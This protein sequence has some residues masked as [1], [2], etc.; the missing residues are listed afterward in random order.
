MVEKGIN[1]Y[2]DPYIIR[3]NEFVKGGFAEKSAKL[4]RLEREWDAEHSYSGPDEWA[5]SGTGSHTVR[6]KQGGKLKCK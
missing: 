4:K 2:G 5:N 1:E 6:R 3:K